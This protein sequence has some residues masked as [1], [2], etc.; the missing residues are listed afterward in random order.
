MSTAKTIGRAVTSIL[1]AFCLAGGVGQAQVTTPPTAAS[2]SKPAVRA[3]AP[4]APARNSGTI[5]DENGA[6]VVDARGAVFAASVLDGSSAEFATDRQGR[7][8][9][10]NLPK[11]PF[12]LLVLPK[13]LDAKGPAPTLLKD[14]PGLENA[15]IRMEPGVP[16]RVRLI[17]QN[18]APVEGTVRFLSVA[19]VEFPDSLSLRESV[20]RADPDG[21]IAF[22]APAGAHV[23]FAEG[24][25]HAGERF[26]RRVTIKPPTTTGAPA[27]ALDLG[28]VTL[29]RG[30]T[31]R[32]IAEND[33][34][35]PLAGVALTTFRTPQTPQTET[36]R[37]Q[38]KED[39][40][41]EMIGLREGGVL[42][43]A[44]LKGH[45]TDNATVAAGDQ[46]V[47]V[48]MARTGAVAGR[49]VDARGEP[50][51]GAR[52]SL[53]GKGNFAGRGLGQGTFQT[54]DFTL[55]ELPPVVAHLLVG[56]SGFRTRTVEDVQISSGQTTDVGE[57]V[58]DRG[59]TLSGRVF[60]GKGTPVA[61][62]RINAQLTGTYDRVTEL[63]DA[64]GQF[65][66]GGLLSGTIDV[67]THAQ[68]FAPLAT[69]I[70]ISKDADPDPIQLVLEKGGLVQGTVRT[71]R[72]QPVIGAIV[73]LSPRTLRS[74]WNRM[75]TTDARG[76]YELKDLPGGPVTVTLLGA[77]NDQFVPIMSVDLDL[78][79]TETTRA[80]M[81]L[82]EIEIVGRILGASSGAGL[83]VSF[84][85]NRGMG[86][87]SLGD[88]RAGGVVPTATGTPRFS[89]LTSEAGLFR[90]V[91]DETGPY[92][93][94][95]ETTQNPRATV[96]RQTVT[97]PDL[98][99]DVGEFAVD[100]TVAG[101]RL[102]GTVVD[103]D[104]GQPIPRAIVGAGTG[105]MSGVDGRFETYVNPG[106]LDLP[107]TASGYDRGQFKITVTE[108]MPEQKFELSRVV[109]SE[110]RVL[111]GV[112]RIADGA[113]AALASIVAIP[114]DPGKTRRLF[115][116]ADA[117]GR[118]SWADAEPG[119]YVVWA[120]LGD[121]RAGR[122]VGKTGADPVEVRLEPTVPV[123]YEV[124]DESGSPLKE[125]PPLSVLTVDGLP[126]ARV[127]LKGEGFL[128][129]GRSVV[130]AGNETRSGRDTVDVRAGEPL[131]IRV[132]AKPIPK[133]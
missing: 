49:V 99:P 11:A 81:V 84:Q 119:R 92:R 132:L 111:A 7:F 76:S 3:P 91:V 10:R 109:P 56:A 98:P 18:G 117:S 52:V 13:R 34:G 51:K 28:V 61:G 107:V 120:T 37:A 115:V 50:V 89:A 87:M 41:F 47:R 22:N 42:L 100:L 104:S 38:T 106:T 55:G 110:D 14:R 77:G 27:A 16:V 31:L 118:F 94:S 116:Q 73:R 67:E 58:L 40:R 65:N 71:R 66:L 8:E 122:T 12:H 78:R 45:F 114:L 79:P 101:V 6:P 69:R 133:K 74:N 15:P 128:P 131:R 121:E 93:V 95:V 39:G 86:G 97:I 113:P 2:Q 123:T 54:P 26:E 23:L 125:S 29:Q 25:E 102:A 46:N 20:A 75:A 60:D 33:L 32:G 96:L 9:V 112:A 30:F 24:P 124:L 72:G 43:T 57:V 19:S 80:D 85:Q 88:G 90:L 68:G 130:M 62:A 103:K 129:P 64:Q 5:V 127:L 108:G 48:V 44:K 59:R 83:R 105:G 53:R 21:R 1:A 82:R 63:S 35:E 126:C 4:P 36:F 17:D 70:E